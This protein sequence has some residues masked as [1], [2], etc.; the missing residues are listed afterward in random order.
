MVKYLGVVQ[1]VLHVALHAC[2]AN[3]QPVDTATG[4][5]SKLKKSSAGDYGSA[6][7]GPALRRGQHATVASTPPWPACQ[8]GQHATVP[9][10]KSM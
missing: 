5:L 9:V 1:H 10:A 7:N 6:M 2:V 4:A 3:L 8:H